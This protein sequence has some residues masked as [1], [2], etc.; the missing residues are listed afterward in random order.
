MREFA[1][2]KQNMDS[3]SKL[4]TGHVP[5]MSAYSSA[6]TG[7]AQTGFFVSPVESNDW[8]YYDANS[9]QKEY[10]DAQISRTADFSHDSNAN[11]SQFSSP[12]ITLD[13]ALAGITPAPSAISEITQFNAVQKLED[14][15][16]TSKKP[17][18]RKELRQQGFFG[19][20]GKNKGEKDDA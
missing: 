11:S 19:G 20:K 5:S 15:G 18:S 10:Y 16:D 13:P 1:K 2:I 8:R 12:N 3:Q 17:L 9:T 6:D 7:A 14:A 4:L